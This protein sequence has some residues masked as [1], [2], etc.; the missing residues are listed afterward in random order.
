MRGFCA[1]LEETQPVR[2]LC[3]EY[4]YDIASLLRVAAADSARLDSFYGDGWLAARDAAVSFDPVS[5]QGI[6]SVAA[7]AILDETF[8]AYAVAVDAV[9]ARYNTM[10]ASVYA[11]ERRWVDA[12]FWTR[13]HD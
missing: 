8:A 12:P 5:S 2:S 9:Y 4:R 11:Q 10:R 7:A 13:R 6:M 3:A 1:S